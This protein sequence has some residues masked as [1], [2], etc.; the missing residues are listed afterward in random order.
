MADTRDAKVGRR[1]GAGFR[2]W[3]ARRSLCGET[4]G[5]VSVAEAGLAGEAHAALDAEFV[6]CWPTGSRTSS[7]AS[8][9]RHAFQPPARLPGGGVCGLQPAREFTCSPVATGAHF[10]HEGDAAAGGVQEMPSSGRNSP[11]GDAAA[12]GS[13]PDSAPRRLQH[14]SHSQGTDSTKPTASVLERP[15]AAGPASATPPTEKRWADEAEVA[16]GSRAVVPMV[17]PEF[18]I[19]Q[20]LRRRRRGRRQPSA[21]SRGSDGV[22]CGG[23][24]R[25][26]GSLG[27]PLSRGASLACRGRP[28]ATELRGTPCSTQ[29][30]LEAAAVSSA[31]LSGR[32]AIGSIGPP[33]LQRVPCGCLGGRCEGCSLPRCG[34]AGFD[35]RKTAAAA[36]AAAAAATAAAAAAT[37]AAAAATLLFD[38]DRC[39]RGRRMPDRSASPD[40]TASSGGES[41]SRGTLECRLRVIQDAM[42]ALRAGGPVRARYDL[43]G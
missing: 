41:S 18:F 28:S 23:R 15:A 7:I 31:T 5:P 3:W 22:G 14:P 12:G 40:S 10:A 29:N 24:R 6:L 21:P 37:A 25:L 9:A 30:T 26:I 33:P 20:R 43:F 16:G 4:L 2:P 19:A 36:T 11:E 8:A 39:R 17:E 27:P 35:V 1:D 32:R 34:I 13:L 38:A 42:E